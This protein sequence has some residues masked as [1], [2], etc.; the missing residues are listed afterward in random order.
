MWIMSDKNKAT[1]RQYVQP[2]ES[3]V[4]CMIGAR[5]FNKKFHM[6]S[7]QL[8]C[9]MKH[10]YGHID[11]KLYSLT[12]ML[13]NLWYDVEVWT[14]DAIYGTA[15]S[16]FEIAKLDIE[17]FSSF[18]LMWQLMGITRTMRDLVKDRPYDITGTNCELMLDTVGLTMT[19]MYDVLK[20]GGCNRTGFK[21]VESFRHLD[22]RL[23]WNC[24]KFDVRSKTYKLKMKNLGLEVTNDKLF[25]NV[26]CSY[27]VD[28]MISA[29]HIGNGIFDYHSGEGKVL[30]GKSGTCR[31]H[32]M[33]CTSDIPDDHCGTLYD[34]IDSN[35]V[36]DDN[37]IIDICETLAKDIKSMFIEWYNGAM[38]IA[39]SIVGMGV[40][41]LFEAVMVDIENR[42]FVI[43]E[44]VIADEH[45]GLN[46]KLIVD[47]RSTFDTIAYHVKSNI[48]WCLDYDKDDDTTWDEVELIIKKAEVRNATK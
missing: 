2:R 43:D 30:I 3:H 24:S 21:L 45:I 20:Q 29:I 32:K 33:I 15:E 17:R 31:N 18:E 6:I 40:G 11:K 19:V 36:E 48:Q 12:R 37:G 39:M 42:A 27:V 34:I 22:D 46:H 44:V 1:G 16:I 5:E 35:V 9:D 23:S 4:M 26:I 25:K 8:I 7:P 41:E 13:P 10:R 14:D 38:G 47:T 28:N